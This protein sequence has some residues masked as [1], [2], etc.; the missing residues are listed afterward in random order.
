LRIVVFV[1][2]LG[3]L[4]ASQVRHLCLVTQSSAL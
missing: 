1:V 2:K 4:H 3:S